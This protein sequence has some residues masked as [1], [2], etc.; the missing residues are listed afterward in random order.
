M[1]HPGLI[2]LGGSFCAING[3]KYLPGSPQVLCDTD[4]GGTG[5]QGERGPC[6]VRWDGKAA[7]R[8]WGLRQVFSGVRRYCWRTMGPECCTLGL[9]PGREKDAC[10]LTLPMLLAQASLGQWSCCL[11]PSP[12][13]RP[14]PRNGKLNEA[15]EVPKVPVRSLRPTLSLIPKPHGKG[16]EGCLP[17]F[18][19]SPRKLSGE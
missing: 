10:L 6:G 11:P 3:T 9:I 18:L 12:S 17:C 7:W 4:S 14:K 2:G 16:E 8:R 13:P 15:V 1:A 19:L 5:F